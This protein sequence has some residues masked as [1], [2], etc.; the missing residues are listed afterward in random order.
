MWKRLK[1]SGE[2]YDGYFGGM[3][4]GTGAINLF[5]HCNPNTGKD[6]IGAKTLL[7]LRKFNVDRFGRRSEVKGEVRTW[8]G[9]ACTSPNQP[10]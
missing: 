5:D 9:V 3:H 1:P 8:H 10:G 4:R 7:T 6:G 2:T